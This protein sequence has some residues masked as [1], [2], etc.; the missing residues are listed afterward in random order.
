MSPPLTHEEHLEVLACIHELHRCRSLAAFPEHVIRA[1]APLIPSNLSAFN[2]V[3]MPRG[4]ILATMSR[5]FPNLADMAVVWERHSGEHP[6]LRYIVETGDGQAVKV[7]DFMSEA[8]WRGL[9]LYRNF[10]RELDAEDQMSVTIRS[11]AGVVLALAF[12]RP[13]RSFTERERVKLNLVRPHV[14]QAY[15]NAEELSGHLDQKQDLETALRETGWGMIA[16]DAAGRM[17]TAT[18]GAPECL[19]RYF[20]DADPEGPLPAALADW[21]ATDP[22]TP[23]TLHGTESTLIVRSPRRSERPLV[24]LSEERR[25]RLAGADRLTPRE[26]EVLRWLAEGKSNPEIATILGV[27]AGTVKLHVQSILAKLGVENRT[28]AATAAREHGLVATSLRSP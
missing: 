9:H 17:A 19:A 18:P 21:L 10:Y 16:L 13:E 4:R 25:R 15:A 22:R 12:N 7:S 14:L 26:I 28:A 23:F 20:P 2:E 6:L 27:S 8:E 3:N 24:L 5:H 11:D 1:L